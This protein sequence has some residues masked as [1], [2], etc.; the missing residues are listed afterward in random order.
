[1]AKSS[2]HICPAKGSSEAHNER[3]KELPHI[4]DA[5]T[6]NNESWTGAEI[7]ARLAEIKKNYEA[8]TGQKMQA[9]ATPIREGVININPETKMQDLRKLADTLHDRFGVQCIQIHIHRDEGHTNEQ[10]EWCTNNHAHMLFDWT[11]AQGETD[12][13]GKSIA[14]KAVRLDKAD[15]AEMQTLVADCLGMQRGESSDLKHLTAIQYKAQAQQEQLTETAK[16]TYVA[17]Q[18]LKAVKQAVQEVKANFADLDKSRDSLKAEAGTARV[19][20][21]KLRNEITNLTNE[22]DILQASVEPLREDLKTKIKSPIES[23][24]LKSELATAKVETATAQTEAQTAKETARAEAKQETAQ[25]TITL[26]QQVRTLTSEAKEAKTEA[27]TAKAQVKQAVQ[28]VTQLKQQVRTLT[29]EAQE[30]KTEATTAK[31]EA[32]EV[33]EE[34]NLLHLLVPPFKR[35]LLDAGFKVKQVLDLF[36]HR[37]TDLQEGQK[38]TYKGQTHTAKEGDFAHLTTDANN[39][40]NGIEINHQSFI[41]LEDNKAQAQP[42]KTQ[43]AEQ[44]AQP[45]KTQQAEQPAQAQPVKAEQPT[46]AQ[47]VKA[48]QPTQAQ[49]VKTQQAEQASPQTH[50][51]KPTNAQKNEKVTNYHPAQ[52]NATDAKETAKNGTQE[53]QHKHTATAGGAETHEEQHKHT[54]PETDEPKHDSKEET[55][56][57]HHDDA[58]HTHTQKRRGMHL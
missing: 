23:I 16:Q 44:P 52:E 39:K 1:M 55:K 6:E 48:Q 53:E 14:G 47:P 11:H 42:V 10:G 5:L 21:V 17:E 57:P 29:S 46:Q 49:P 56:A 31:A 51:N 33:K 36:K 43:Q 50:K 25:D 34:F 24:R 37:K 2:I 58:T 54:A 27:T 12:K 18:Q 3:L 40:A 22:R 41:K 32:Q 15:M 20:V 28:V 13:Q 7:S 30:A 8:T 35:L 9:K 45:V 26:K 38:I 4:N 19:E